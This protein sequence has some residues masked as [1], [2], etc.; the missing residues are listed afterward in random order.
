MT[1][2]GPFG[3][4]Q[5]QVL[6]SDADASRLAALRF[7]D[8]S[9]ILLRKRA[10]PGG[11]LDALALAHLFLDGPYSPHSS[12]SVKSPSPQRPSTTT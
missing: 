2:R 3:P 1:A 8:I 7:L 6:R 11:R 12:V 5:K 10:L 9:R 4:V